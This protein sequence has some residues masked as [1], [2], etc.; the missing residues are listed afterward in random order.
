MKYTKQDTLIILGGIIFLPDI[1]ILM[2]FQGE[3]A[4]KL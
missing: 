4:E 1:I 3:Q 2:D